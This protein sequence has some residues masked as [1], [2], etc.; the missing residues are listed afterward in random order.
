MCIHYRDFI[1]GETIANQIATSVANSKRTIVLLSE[2]FLKSSWGK[3]EFRTAHETAM[4]EKRTRV[5]MI[6]YEDIDLEG[7]IYDELRAYLNTHTYIK[8]GDP[9]FWD[10][11]RYALPH[12]KYHKHKLSNKLNNLMN[13]I[14]KIDLVKTPITPNNESTPPVILDPLLLK[15]QPFEFKITNPVIC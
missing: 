6:L 8:W 13:N 7:E 12:S 1:A 14:D 4:R 9:W 15:K 2:N 5:I 3:M 11:L 10:K